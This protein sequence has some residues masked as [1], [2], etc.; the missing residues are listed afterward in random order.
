[1]RF[2][3]R[4]SGLFVVFAILCSLPRP[5]AARRTNFGLGIVGGDPTGLTGELVFGRRT[6]MDFTVGLDTFDDDAVYVAA[7]Y[8]I[9]VVDLAPRGSVGIPLYLGFGAF[10]VDY[11]RGNN[12]DLIVVGPRVPFGLQLDFRAVPLVVFAELAVRFY[13]ISNHE[14]GDDDS[15]VDGSIGFRIYF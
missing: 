12:D 3:R 11:D 9:R 13:M 14:R 8:L 15:D 1:M 7:D 10:V 5:A 4:L 2:M 6:S